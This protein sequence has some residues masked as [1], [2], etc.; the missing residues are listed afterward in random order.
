MSVFVFKLK[1]G[2]NP[3]QHKA[4]SQLAGIQQ[5]GKWMYWTTRTF[6]CSPFLLFWQ[7]VKA[8]NNPMKC[9]LANTGWL[10]VGAYC[11]RCVPVVLAAAQK[12]FECV[13]YFASKWTI[14]RWWWCLFFF[15]IHFQMVPVKCYQGWSQNLNDRRYLYRQPVFRMW[16][17]W[18][19]FPCASL[20]FHYGGC[21]H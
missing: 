17:N 11:F 4:T 14:S 20:W 6:F 8:V 16:L 3:Y 18:L 12:L 10:M 5:K 7:V 19:L 2:V 21:I 9:V 15:Y 1:M 13:F